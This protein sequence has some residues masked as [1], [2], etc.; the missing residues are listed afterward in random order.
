[1]KTKM[2]VAVSL[3]FC[4]FTFANEMN[5]N[6]EKVEKDLTAQIEIKHQEL[7]QKISKKL[8]ANFELQFEKFMSIENLM[9][10]TN[11]EKFEDTKYYNDITE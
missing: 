4:N 2:L 8:E 10:Q 9:I 7:Q 6:F 1:M 3:F 11:L 5:F